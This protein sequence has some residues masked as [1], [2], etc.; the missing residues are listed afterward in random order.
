[1]TARMLKLMRPTFSLNGI[2]G[3]GLGNDIHQGLMD[4]ELSRKISQGKGLGLGSAI[5]RTMIEREEKGSA[6]I[7]DGRQVQDPARERSEER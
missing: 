2:F 1:M 3:K 4:Q 7:S 6:A 5:Y